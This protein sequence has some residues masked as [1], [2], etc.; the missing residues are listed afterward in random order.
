[1]YVDV[2]YVYV[3]ALPVERL[4]RLPTRLRLI[5]LVVEL[6]LFPRYVTQLHTPPF[7]RC[8]WYAF[9]TFA[10][11]THLLVVP[12]RLQHVAFTFAVE[13]LH[14]ILRCHVAHCCCCLLLRYVTFVVVAFVVVDYICL[15]WCLLHCYLRLLRC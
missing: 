7:Y 5:L 2:L 10:T 12:T 6:T 15:R 3:V 9:V 13:R 1:M 11:F 8:I 4:L 14:T